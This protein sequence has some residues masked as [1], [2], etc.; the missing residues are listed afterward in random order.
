MF[1]ESWTDETEKKTENLSRTNEKTYNLQKLDQEIM[2]L[3]Y[4][5]TN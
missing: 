5:S 1:R 3:L 4:K 2:Q